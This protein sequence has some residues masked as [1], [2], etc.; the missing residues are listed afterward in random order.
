VEQLGT[1]G[2]PLGIQ[3]DVNYT[4]RELDLAAGDL[5]VA[6]TDGLWEARRDGVQF[7]DARLHELL[8]L[9]GRRLAPQALVA[10][11]R[12]EAERWASRL[13]DDLVILAVRV[14]R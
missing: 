14:R 13:H 7:G 4:E 12:I 5:L 2:F 9:H 11:L 10:L 1:T 3:A 6:A 8:S